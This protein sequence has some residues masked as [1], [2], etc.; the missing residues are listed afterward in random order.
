MDNVE[1][2]VDSQVVNLTD[3]TFDHVINSN[4]LVLVDFWAPWCGPCR[5]FGPVI[6]QLA[7]LYKGRAVVAKLDISENGEQSL[8]HSVKSVP[9]VV[10]FFNGKQVERSIGS[11]TI[12]ALQSILDPYL[13]QNPI[14]NG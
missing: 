11:L 7:E 12:E 13:N 4:K 10:V 14:K 5:R 2:V 9:T 6:E 1:Q 8:K 3:A